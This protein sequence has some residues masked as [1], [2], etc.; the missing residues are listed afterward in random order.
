MK[1]YQNELS[2]KTSGSS[3]SL[4]PSHPLP[5]S[6]TCEED[7]KDD[8]PSTS[9]RHWKTFMCIGAF[10]LGLLVFTV[11]FYAI[12]ESGSS[13]QTCNGLSELCSK[14]MNDAIFPMAYAAHSNLASE[15][16]PA[17]QEHNL[18]QQLKTGIR[19]V[20][21]SVWPCKTNSSKACACKQACVLGESDL[22]EL[23]G[24]LSS[25]LAA[26]KDEVVVAFFRQ[27]V[28]TAVLQ[29]TIVD[30]GLEMYAYTAAS[31]VAF[32]W[33]TLQQL[34]DDN[35][36]AV[37]FADNANSATY[38]PTNAVLPWLLPTYD[39]CWSSTDAAILPSDLTCIPSNGMNGTNK[40]GIFTYARTQ[41][42]PAI[43]HARVLNTK[44]NI[45]KGVE[46]CCNAVGVLPNF[47]SLA[48]ASID[49]QHSGASDASESNTGIDVV[50][51]LNNQKCPYK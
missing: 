18:L 25:F 48:W 49:L 43:S 31:S 29:Q 19:A 5:H 26:E 37:L 14:R 1:V 28:E 20:D 10:A 12:Q 34:I 9:Y 30:A 45:Q 8:E 17:A 16:L 24:Q 3:V 15:V 7:T 11:V 6:R 39:Y 4:S 51:N 22:S 50:R 46:L 32:Q 38:D 21:I 35:K 41:P 47:V 44:A 36:R 27:H 40:L 13:S 23:L 33:P 2:L 42:A